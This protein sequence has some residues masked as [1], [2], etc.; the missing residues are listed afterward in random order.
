[1]SAIN[2]TH[3]SGS[4]FVM[5]LGFFSIFIIINV[6]YNKFYMMCPFAY[7]L[8]GFMWVVRTGGKIIPFSFKKVKI[9]K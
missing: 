1:V 3:A 6:W 2:K 9:S 8:F 4:Y 7:L 5:I